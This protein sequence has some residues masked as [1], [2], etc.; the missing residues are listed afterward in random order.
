MSDYDDNDYNDITDADFTSCYDTNDE[1]LLADVYDMNPTGNDLDDRAL[2]SEQSETDTVMESD[3]D[4]NMSG[5]DCIPNEEDDDELDDT[6][7]IINQ[8]MVDFFS[9]LYNHISK[10]NDEFSQVF[11]NEALEQFNNKK[12]FTE[13]HTKYNV[14]KYGLLIRENKYNNH[15]DAYGWVFDCNEPVNIHVSEEL[16]RTKTKEE[17]FDII[18]CELIRKNKISLTPKSIPTQIFKLLNIDVSK[19]MKQ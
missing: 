3:I 10:R 16:K 4:Y 18:M 8:H 2:A 14:D 13:K 6:D 12:H 5:Q 11:T 9:K 15:N 1:A 17:I 19:Y 7:I